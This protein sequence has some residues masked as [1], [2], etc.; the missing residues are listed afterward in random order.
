[1]KRGKKME[2]RF[3]I[4]YLKKGFRRYLNRKSGILLKDVIKWTGK[5]DIR[6]VLFGIK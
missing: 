3:F 1:M 4:N 5:A 6:P 2:Q